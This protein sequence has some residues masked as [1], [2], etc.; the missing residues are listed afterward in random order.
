[1]AKR[2][3]KPPRIPQLGNHGLDDALHEYA[4]SWSSSEPNGL[5]ALRRATWIQTVKPQM[6]C[7]ELQGRMLSMMSHMIRPERVLELGTFTGYATACWAEGLAEG[8]MVDTVDVN[9]EL[10]AIQNAHWELLG[11]TNRIRRHVGKAL[12]VLESEVLF[13][14]DARPFDVV[15]VDADKEHQRTY[16]DWA[17][18]HVREDGWIVVDN[19]LWWG[20]VLRVTD[21]SSEDPYAIRIHELN[22]Y[23]KG[24]PDLDNVVLP[25]RDG[26]H[27]ARKKS[28]V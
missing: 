5:E 22:E 11:I 28:R 21:G 6:L 16:V 23:V 12:D 9:D 15:F 18:D 27:V 1:M 13:E 20:E 3:G 7:D 19:V 24:H 8:G 17:V 26:L 25:L 14:E 2:R 10:H 4:T